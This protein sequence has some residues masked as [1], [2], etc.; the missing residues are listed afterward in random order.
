[1][2]DFL[3]DKRQDG[4]LTVEAGGLVRFRYRV[5]VHPDDAKRA[6]IAARYKEYAAT[7]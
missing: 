3:N 1:V 5:V 7:R 2:S 6:N 4:S